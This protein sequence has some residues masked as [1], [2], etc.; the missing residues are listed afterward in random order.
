MTTASTARQDDDRDSTAPPATAAAAKAHHYAQSM[1]SGFEGREAELGAA[2]QE[3]LARAGSALSFAGREAE[4]G[5]SVGVALKTLQNVRPYVHEVNDAVVKAHLMAIQFAKDHGG[6]AQLVEQDVRTMRPINQRLRA[7]VEKSGWREI[8]L[9]GMFDHTGCH[10]QFVL[11]TKVEPGRRTWQ[12]PFGRVLG[13][14]R[15]IGQFDLTEREIH[16]QWTRP[17]ILGYAADIGVRVAVSD[18][19]DDGIVVVE[20]TD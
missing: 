7:V 1:R 11:E 13:A 2:V 4:V 14:S 17:R 19:R 6:I 5:L 16:E 20:L 8:A 10:Y 9:I 12:S 3:A 15:A 18:W